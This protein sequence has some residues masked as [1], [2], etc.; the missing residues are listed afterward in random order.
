M[1]P[2]CSPDGHPRSA[3]GGAFEHRHLGPRPQFAVALAQA[4]IFSFYASLAASARSRKIFRMAHYDYRGLTGIDFE[5][6]VQSLL[7]QELGITLEAFAPGKD[8]GIDLRHSRDPS[9]SVIVQCK[10]LKTGFSAL[11]REL[12]KKEYPKIARLKP[13]RYIVATSVALT[14]GNKDDIVSALHPYLKNPQDVYGENDITTLLEKYPHIARRNIKLYLTS[15]SALSRTL[16]NDLFCSAEFVLSEAK[17]KAK[18]YIESVMHDDARQILEQEHVCLISGPPGVGKTTLAEMLLLEYQGNGWEVYSITKNINDVVRVYNEERKQIFIYD[19]FLGQISSTE[20]LGK[21]EDALLARIIRQIVNDDRKRLL[22]TT[23][24]YILRDAST[25]YETLARLHLERKTCTIECSS[26]GDTAKATMLYN[27]IY[28]S[29]LPPEWIHILGTSGDFDSF[30]VHKGF[31]PRV[32][33]SIIDIA[34]GQTFEPNQFLEFFQEKFNYPDEIWNHI[35]QTYLPPD[36]RKLLLAMASTEGKISLDSLKILYQSIAG[37]SSHD[38]SLRFQHVYQLIERTFIRTDKTN[39]GYV[40]QISNPSIRDY[41]VRFATA[42]R[43]SIRLILSTAM[44]FSQITF[45]WNFSSDQS[46]NMEASAESLRRHLV[47]ACRSEFIA[48]LQRTILG[49]DPLRSDS[50][51]TDRI[52]PFVKLDERLIEYCKAMDEIGAIPDEGCLRDALKG[53]TAGWEHRQGQRKIC[54][55]ILRLVKEK[56]IVSAEELLPI[57]QLAKEFILESEFSNYDDF[58]MLKKFNSTFPGLLDTEELESA[59]AAFEKWLSIAYPE[60]RKDEPDVLPEAI[61]WIREVSHLLSIGVDESE[62]EL[63]EERIAAYQAS[64]HVREIAE[65]RRYRNVITRITSVEYGEYIRNLCNS[66]AN[67]S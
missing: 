46:D 11:L 6:L 58:D 62:I 44:F 22:L 8:S 26:Y 55:D 48:A 24:E 23:R 64:E 7:Q 66:L 47:G 16:N 9:K 54:P 60:L 28:H 31:V 43:D 15:W 5:D 13:A 49:P 1:R 30:V 38:T 61:S 33:E 53:I 20:K 57:A 67:Y 4:N 45:L 34:R 17:R 59:R 12:Q 2:P 27:H 50:V 3:T 51:G 21:N 52:P 63:A 10:H 65:R 37:E 39:N 29:N 25:K 56:T 18:I 36:A 41:L 42:D 19:D 40:V 32:L 35:F 14:P